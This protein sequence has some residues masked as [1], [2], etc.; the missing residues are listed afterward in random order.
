MGADK[1]PPMNP[2]RMRLDARTGWL[3]SLLV[4]LCALACSTPRPQ[5][6][7][8][9][10]RNRVDASAFP[11]VDA[12]VLLDR[13]EVTYN[14]SIQ[15]ERPYAEAL[16]LR[17]IQVLSEKALS[18]SK[19]RI[20]YDD[21]SRVLHVQ[22]RVLKPD[23]RIIEMPT[24]RTVKLPR[25]APDTAAARLYNDDGY[26]LGKVGQLEVGDVV[27][28]SYLRVLRDP[29]WLEPLQIGGDYPV[30]R[31]EVILNHPRAYELDFRVTRF[32]EL[33]RFRPTKL[34]TMIE[35]PQGGEALAGT[36]LVFVFENE[37]AIY[38]EPLQ[39]QTSALSTQVHVTLIGYTVQGKRY[40]GYRHW[41]DIG[42][43]YN[44]LVAG[45][46][47][48]DA[49]VKELIRKR[50][51]LR[52]KKQE[53]LLD[54]Q[55][56]LQNHI[57]DVPSFLNLAALPA[58]APE[59]ILLHRTGDSKD[60]ASLG[61]AMLRALGLDGLPILVSR[62]GSFA[63]IPDLPTPALFN[64][65]ILAV[66]SGGD[67]FF[68]D[69]AT[70]D[71]PPGR[72]PGSLQGQR[73][74][75]VRQDGNAEFI[76]LPSDNVDDNIRD[77]R[78]SFVLDANGEA[79]GQIILE[80]VGLEAAYGRQLLREGG[81]ELARKME[82]AF[83]GGQTRSLKWQSVHAVS[84]SRNDDK[85][86]RLQV[87]LEPGSVGE[88]MGANL[89]VYLAQLLGQPHPYLWRERRQMPLLR[90]HRSRE[91]HRVTLEMPAGYGV[92]A[93]PASHEASSPL[94]QWQDQWSV[95]NGALFLERTLVFA[96][97]TVGAEQYP[98]YR[99]PIDR[100]WQFQQNGL[101]LIPGGERGES[102]G[103]APF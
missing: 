60:Q 40:E 99:A 11:D 32:G 10:L 93:L 50:G 29:R 59:E 73:G 84:L 66:P 96:E 86:L 20:P 4:A 9:D 67:Y 6:E 36:R 56:F 22:A 55:R 77:Y 83:G 37:P 46:D 1:Y 72:L 102:Y 76:D 33:T 21:R 52:A 41:S 62:Q 65:V 64:H 78:Y 61:L 13:T 69:P 95:A 87:V 58:R 24:D 30:V 15:Q 8:F 5:M 74:L 71:L 47:V 98:Q 57:E 81:P 92:A 31:G 34:P 80:L 63:S 35:N 82:Q 90:S 44:T 45:K 16:H 103:N 51:G 17:R 12:V 19:F 88:R 23:G 2:F 68:L 18:L 25:F 26:L 39:P 7:R 27:E 89:D 79:K 38:P 100:L 3:G 85:P 14:Y 101:A 49:A 94:I 43:W 97:R 70:P 42:R 54:V 48:P 91:R 53:K 28:L 75:L